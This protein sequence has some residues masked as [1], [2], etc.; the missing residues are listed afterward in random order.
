MRLHTPRRI[1]LVSSRTASPRP[2]P[3]CRLHSFHTSLLRPFPASRGPPSRRLLP[4]VGWC[5]VAAVDV[6]FPVGI[7][8][9][10][11]SLWSTQLDPTHPDSSSI[12]ATAGAASTRAGSGS[13]ASE[14]RTL[15]H[16][17]GGAR[18]YGDTSARDSSEPLAFTS[19]GAIPSPSFRRR[20]AVVSTEPKLE[21][22]WHTEVNQ[23]ASSRP[24]RAGWHL[25]RC[26]RDQ[27]R[28]LSMMVK[29]RSTGVDPHVTTT[30]P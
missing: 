13:V 12:D 1:P 9:E 19:A 23:L 6:E 22:G 15:C 20:A 16:H 27:R 25:D 28:T 8:P 4:F 26:R 7:E 30:T 10:S 2:L 11:S 17:G 5:R 24:A 29:L 21:R 18:D 3:S 14:A